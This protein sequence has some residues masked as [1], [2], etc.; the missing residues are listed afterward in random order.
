M[1]KTGRRG[2]SNFT[3]AILLV[4][5]MCQVLATGSAFS[6][7]YPVGDHPMGIDVNHHHVH[8]ASN[9]LS[10]GMSESP[11]SYGNSPDSFGE[12]RDQGH[13]H[14]A[15]N[16]T[17]SVYDF[18]AESVSETVSESLET[19]HEHANHSHAPSHPPADTVFMSG[20]FQS[21]TLIDDDISYFNLGY[22]PPIPPPHV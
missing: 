7:Q 13:Q 14:A 6:V 3:L 20:F 21:E 4:V 15:F 12:G 10:H 19:E 8:S 17:E 1:E 22:A 11:D 9:R 2:Q 16:A 5:L 18:F